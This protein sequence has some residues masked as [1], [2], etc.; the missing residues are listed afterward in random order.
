MKGTMKTLFLTLALAIGAQ[1]TAIYTNGSLNGAGADGSGDLLSGNWV[2]DSFTVSGSVELTGGA[3]LVTDGTGTPIMNLNW[4]ILSTSDGSTIIA[5]GSE[6]PTNTNLNCTGLSDPCDGHPYRQLTFTLPGVV[7]GA[8]TYYLEL[9]ATGDISARWQNVP[10]NSG[11]S[12]AFIGTG[13]APLGFNGGP[14]PDTGNV[15]DLT[16]NQVPEPA[17]FLLVGLGLLALRIPTI[18]AFVKRRP[19]PDKGGPIE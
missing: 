14:G 9:N 6:T 19:C 8:G 11:T 16:G 17:T 2:A 18:M 7:L 1:A 3:F 4:D 13:Q 10:D 12:T 5:S 15:F